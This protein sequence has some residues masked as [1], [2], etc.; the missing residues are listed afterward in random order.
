MLIITSQL[1]RVLTAGT[2]VS[3]GAGGA[4][5]PFRKR[6]HVATSIPRGAA[7]SHD[8]QMTGRTGAD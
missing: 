5:D 1:R 8:G 7:A 4:R 3:E 6:S 2:H